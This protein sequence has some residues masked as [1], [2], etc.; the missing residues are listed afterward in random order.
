MAV[1]RK[2]Q[3]VQPQHE[4]QTLTI[5]HRGGSM[6]VVRDFTAAKSVTFSKSKA[7]L[8]IHLT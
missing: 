2:K 8:I 6:M 3:L 1:Y 5:T 7:Y 4:C